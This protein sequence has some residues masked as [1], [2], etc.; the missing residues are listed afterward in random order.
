MP[1]ELK[2]PL[3]NIPGIGPKT[4]RI[5]NNQNLST[6]EDLLY[7]FP[8]KY[9]V[10]Q[11]TT[12]SQA[13]N[14]QLVILKG[15]LGPIRQQR[16]GRL[17]F[18]TAYFEDQTGRIVLRWFNQSYLLRQLHPGTTYQLQG[19]IS[20][21]RHQQQILNPKLKPTTDNSFS[22]IESI[23]PQ[24]KNLKTSW[25]QRTIARIVELKP[26]IT[27]NLPLP[28]LQQHNLISRKQA[29][30]FIHQPNNQFQLN[31]AKQR[32]AFEEL[33]LLQ[34]H[35]L[36]L[37]RQPKPKA[38]PLQLNSKDIIKFEKSLSF[39]LTP[40]Q[41]QAIQAIY[42][43]LKQPLAMNR[44][45]LGDVGTGKTVV[46]AFA[47]YQAAKNHQ[48]TYIMAPT[49]TLAEQLHQ[50]ISQFLKPHQIKV[51]LLTNYHRPQSTY[52][53][54]I[55]THALLFQQPP[56]N[57]GLVIIDEQ[58]RFGVEQRQ[59]LSRLQP[60]PHQL[61]MTATP[62]PRTLALT[63]MSHLDLSYLKEK[64]AHRLP[65][66][67]FLVPQAK[68]TSAYHWIEEKI[69]QDN[70]QVF[71]VAP[72]IEESDSDQL[73]HLKS[74]TQ[75][76]QEFQEIF[77]KI[78]IGLLHGQ[79][80]PSAKTDLISQF[81]QG[82]IKIL[83]STTVIEVGIDIPK[84]NIIIIESAERFGLAQLHQLRGRVGRGQQQGYCLL[85]PSKLSPKAKERLQA[86]T[87]YQDGTKLAQL[88]MKL[89]GPGE[90]WGTQQHGFF[91]LKLADIFD[92]QLVK[93]TLQA[94]KLSLSK[95]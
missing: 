1:F 12:I 63:L 66:K 75:I 24:L 71:V 88:D 46:A 35:S 60:T 25:F 74:A 79:L 62:I 68:R 77:P 47:A 90:V 39:S 93:A 37:Q 27:E 58:H 67:T 9:L 78:T 76:Y 73:K 34:K 94:A 5:L 3:I 32:L 41:Q 31:Q 42:H 44:L 40:S 64:P 8:K 82:K 16:K 11:P 38:I 87:K 14:N 19:Q 80:K 59:Q 52:Q 84:A 81:S 18:Q 50:T 69:T 4:A 91:Q 48:I 55:G 15:I 7:F 20:F 21:F 22:L 10:Y 61:I 2:T 33:F 54:L 89:R 53:V 13:N 51:E 45:L 85:F 56:T 23:Y 28:V 17:N 26:Q 6:I 92:E 43:N 83:V 30:Y 57:L 29:L 95:A 72:L 36:Q 65:I 86:L 70:Y 49:Q